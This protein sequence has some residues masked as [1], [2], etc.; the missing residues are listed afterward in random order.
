[1]SATFSDAAPAPPAGLFHVEPIA[2][3]ESREP[4][5]GQPEFLL[6]EMM[7]GLVALDPERRVCFVWC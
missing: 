3:Q 6:E 1:V 2:Q 5:V 7:A 4:K